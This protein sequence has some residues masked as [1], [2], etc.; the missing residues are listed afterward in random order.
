MIAP[1]ARVNPLLSEFRR[2]GAELRPSIPGL[3]LV[4]A[5]AIVARSLHGLIPSPEMARAISEVFIAVLLGFH[6]RNAIRFSPRFEPG[7]RFALQRILRFGIILLGVRLSFQD[8]VNT[9]L[10]ASLLIF[11][12]VAFALTLAYVV[13][14]FLRIPARLAA[15]IGVGTAI[16]G[17]SAIIATAPVIE[18][19]DEDVSYAVATITFFGTLAVLL[20]PSI[21][22][23][24]GMTDRV[25]GMWAGTAILDTSQVV[26][27]GAAFSDAA[28]DIATVVKLVRNTL[29]V[30]LILL[31][32]VVYTR[33]QKKRDASV[34]VSVSKIVPWFVIGFLGMTLVRTLGNAYGFLPVNVSAPGNL[35][36]A[37]KFLLAV[38]EVAKFAILMALAAIGL[39]T[40]AESIRRTG[41][42]PVALGFAVG[43]ALGVFSL[44]LIRLFT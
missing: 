24:T 11:A 6:A 19:R 37:A 40:D 34:K 20:Y 29:M 10:A 28:R 7:I 32:G 13:G 14:R 2:I 5:V 25:F 18:A 38:D 16:C 3:Y 23:F 26:A 12:C 43:G 8:V 27:A 21:G 4:T 30:P 17:N 41:V 35:V 39:S 9:G 31:I 1:E 33:A 44:V 36:T 42:K 15:L 22:Y